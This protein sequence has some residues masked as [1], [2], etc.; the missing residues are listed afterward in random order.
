MAL[1]PNQILKFIRSITPGARPTGRTYGEPYVNMS[2]KQFGVFDNSNNPIDLIGVPFFSQSIPYPVGA[3]VNYGGVLYLATTAVAAGVWNPAQWAQVQP[4]GGFSTGD[5]KLTIK[6]VADPTWIMM[7]DGTIG[8]STSGAST[9]AD[10]AAQALFILMWNNV[11][12]TWAPVT[13][14][15]RGANAA[16]DWAAHKKMQLTRQLGRAI[17]IGGAGA[18][19]TNRPLGAYLGEESHTPTQAEMFNHGHPVTLGSYFYT[20]YGSLYIVVDGGSATYACLYGSIAAPSGTSSPVGSSTPHN[21]IQP[22][23]AW[24]IMMKL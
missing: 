15:G 12:D 22:S 1:N 13:P 3:A 2:D 10:P 4:A 21:V 8:D 5:A 16:A 24:N 9:L 14:G 18:G 6:N 17:I 19:L 11:L 7:N 20:A 23:S